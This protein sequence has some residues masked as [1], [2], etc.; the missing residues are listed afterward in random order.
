MGAVTDITTGEAFERELEQ[1][2][3]VSAAGGPR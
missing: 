2:D 3:L 1:N